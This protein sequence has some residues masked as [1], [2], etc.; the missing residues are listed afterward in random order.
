MWDRILCLHTHTPTKWVTVHLLP[1]RT[2]SPHYPSCIKITA[3]QIWFSKQTCAS[4]KYVS[5]PG[6]L[7]LLLV[8]L[9]LSMCLIAWFGARGLRTLW[10]GAAGRGVCP[11]KAG[12]AQVV[13]AWFKT[14]SSQQAKTLKKPKVFAAVWKDLHSSKFEAIGGA[15]WQYGLDIN[16]KKI[17]SEEEYKI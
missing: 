6:E 1:V 9:N 10:E 17:G 5:N 16:Q 15:R 13:M 14:L 11:A 2:Y 12:T 8:W 3:P 4:S 7:M